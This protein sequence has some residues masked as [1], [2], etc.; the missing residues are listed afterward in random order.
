MLTMNTDIF[1]LARSTSKRLP[2]KHM[3]IINGKPIIENLVDRMKKSNKIR[4]IVVCTTINF[5]DDKLVH[6]L[7]KES[8]LYYR[9]SEHD[10]LSRFLGAS[11]KFKTDVIVD[12]EGDKIY[13][14]PAY[15]DKIIEELTDP[16][17]DFVI[18]NDSEEK[19]NPNNHLVHGF[20][21]AGMKTSALQKLCGIKTTENTETGY[22]EFFTKSEIFNCKY[23]I[24]D[25]FKDNP[26]DFRLT[27][28][29]EEDLKL[30]NKIFG[31]LGNN[32]SSDDV[33]ELFKQKPSLNEITKPIIEKWNKHYQ[34][35][36]TKYE[37]K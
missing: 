34:D 2:S 22:L 3:K 33:L 31:E 1:I 7:E 17:I 30:A 37:L 12:V 5:S 18:G 13:T 24:P 11:K 8:V 9:G 20:I 32:F 29:Y 10:I 28:D 16:K 4:K 23:I 36:I 14:D 27:L 21:P 6:F 26:E 15:V 35:N 25:N 19:F